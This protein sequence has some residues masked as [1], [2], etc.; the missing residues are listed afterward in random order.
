MK[1][2]HDALNDEVNKI[3][4]AVYEGR[5]NIAASAASH[6]TRL[7]HSLESKDDVFIGEVLGVACGQVDYVMRSYHVVEKDMS[8]FDQHMAS[9]IG[10]L[11]EHHAGQKNICQ[12]L[13]DIRYVV[14]TLLLTAEHSYPPRTTLPAGQGG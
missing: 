6:L 4:V 1:S 8:A 10:K 3:V 12:V 9:H 14:T 5:Y 13:Q 2:P 7:A 11:A